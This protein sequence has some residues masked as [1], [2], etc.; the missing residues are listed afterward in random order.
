MSVGKSAP[1]SMSVPAGAIAGALADT[2]RRSVFAAVQ[3]GAAHVDDVVTMTG[4]PVAQVGKAL[5]KLVDV[6]L[7]RVNRGQVVVAGEVFQQAARA[8]LAR[9]AMSEHDSLP[10]ADRKVMNAF[11]VDGRL[12]SIPSSIGKRLVI[13][14]WLAQLFEPGR[15]YSEPMVNLIIGQ[16]H[17]D[18]AALRR[19]L[20][21]EGFLDREAGVYWRSGGSIASESAS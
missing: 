15:R 16:R 17:A 13:L 5:G 11:V 20:V 18:T 14:D 8:A 9:P 19:Y 3:L 7:V 12:Q 21:D 6:G 2:D 1:M 10:A 4:L